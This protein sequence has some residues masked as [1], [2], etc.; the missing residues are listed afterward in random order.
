MNI[1][2]LSTYYKKRFFP[3]GTYAGIGTTCVEFENVMSIK[4][5]PEG[6]EIPL[7]TINSTQHNQDTTN[8]IHESKT[9]CKSKN[10]KT[11]FAINFSAIS[12]WQICLLIH[13]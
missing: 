9:K 1:F 13:Y 6:T 4:P 2:A 11:L 10:N 3:T 8:P 12:C 7:S 5:V